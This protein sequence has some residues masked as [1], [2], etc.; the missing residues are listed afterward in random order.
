MREFKTILPFIKENRRHYFFGILMLILVDA[1][2]L[3]SPQV[4]RRFADLAQTG[5]LTDRLILELVAWISGL[6]LFM[7]VGRYFWRNAIFGAGRH[8]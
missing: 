3:Y 8:L 2:S 6:G 4:V 7:A 1:A 5:Q